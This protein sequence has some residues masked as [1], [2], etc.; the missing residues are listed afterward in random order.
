MIHL[1]RFVPVPMLPQLRTSLESPND[2]EVANAALLLAACGDRAMADR[3]LDLAL[4]SDRTVHVRN[5]ALT[6]YDQI[7]SPA[8]A[9]RLL[10][11]QDWDEPTVLSRIDAA[12]GL[13]TPATRDWCSRRLGPPTR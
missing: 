3:L 6:A 4:D 7:G 10:D 8:S 2:V 12:A 9:Q 1:A 5:S 13:M 11:I